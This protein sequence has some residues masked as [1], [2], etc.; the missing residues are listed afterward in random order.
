MVESHESTRQRVEP[1]L[2]TNHEDHI[3]GKGYYSMN[4]YNLVH[5]F[6]PMPQAMKNSGSEGSSGQGMEEARNNPSMATGESQEQ[7]GGY[8]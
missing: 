5:E 8:S 1:S 2:P 7:Q 4:H 3:A 6:I